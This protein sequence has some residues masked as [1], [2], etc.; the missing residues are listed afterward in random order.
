[1][2]VHACLYVYVYRERRYERI[3]TI[4]V[5]CVCDVRVCVCVSDVCMNV[6]VMCV[7]FVSML[8]WR[9]EE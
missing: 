1:M 3:C 2:Y 9:T 4:C 7:A 6:Y 5:M 8:V